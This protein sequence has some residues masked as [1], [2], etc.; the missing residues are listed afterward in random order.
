MLNIIN[1]NSTQTINYNKNKIIALSGILSEKMKTVPVYLVNEETMDK[2]YPL[3]KRKLLDEECLKELL[4]HERRKITTSFYTC[5]P[6][7]RPAFDLEIYDYL[8]QKGYPFIPRKQWPRDG[9]R[10]CYL[11]LGNENYIIITPYK[12][13]SEYQRIPYISLHITKNGYYVDLVY[14]KGNKCLECIV[15]SIVQYLQNTGYSLNIIRD[16]QYV[17]RY[18][19]N[20]NVSNCQLAIDDFYGKIVPI[21]DNVLSSS[22]LQLQCPN[23]Q[24]VINKIT[25]T[26]FEELKQKIEN[27]IKEKDCGKED[28]EKIFEK[29]I[30]ERISKAVGLYLRNIPD[31]LYNQFNNLKAPAI[32]ISPERC[33]DLGNKLNISAD[34]VFTKTLIHEYSHAYLDVDGSD[35]YKKPWW[36]IIEESLANYIVFDR[37]K[38]IEDMAE[39]SLTNFLLFIT[40]R[41]NG[42]MANV[43][44]LISNQ[45]LEYRCSLV[46]IERNNFPIYTPSLFFTGKSYRD[47]DKY[48]R[49][50]SYLHKKYGILDFIFI[51]DLYNLWKK[52]KK[53]NDNELEIFFK[54]L[55]LNLVESILL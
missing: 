49:K 51:P 41:A 3:Q 26:E 39:K 46:L 55:A 48:F 16:N 50:L 23:C 10:D 43:I 31:W 28:I 7:N 24:N 32:F 45:P 38:S 2:L 37:F 29:C 52:Y 11:F 27:H 42:D 13:G 20:L 33:I 18:R 8:I 1:L 21:I 35:Y 12:G 36:K 14:D 34:F 44:K 53:S 15:E 4:N 9:S 47:L 54:Q 17:K 6:K 22:F 5:F 30:K 40:S 25:S 19:L